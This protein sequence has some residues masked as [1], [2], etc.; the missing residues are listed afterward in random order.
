MN[1]LRTNYDTP[2][3]KILNRVNEKIDYFEYLGAGIENGGRKKQ[4]GGMV[5][6]IAITAK[7]ITQPLL[8]ACY[9][10]PP[11]HYIQTSSERDGFILSLKLRLFWH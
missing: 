1:Q 3:F 10:F 4:G 9:S 11:P 2:V 5:R 7:Q 8:N 6:R